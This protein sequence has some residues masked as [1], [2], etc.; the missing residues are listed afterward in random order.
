MLLGHADMLHPCHTQ[1]FTRFFNPH[2]RRV[3]LKKHED[4]YS[5]VKLDDFDWLL[6]CNI[7]SATK[8][9][10][11]ANT[12]HRLMWAPLMPKAEAMFWG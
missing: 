5:V 4:V 8:P 11:G 1:T 9:L 2:L 12:L 10:G 7:P 3:R 6:T